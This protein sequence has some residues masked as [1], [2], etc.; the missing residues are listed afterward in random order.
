MNSICEC[1]VEENEKKSKKY[2]WEWNKQ[3]KWK[4]T[5]ILTTNYDH[6]KYNVVDIDENEATQIHIIRLKSDGKYERQ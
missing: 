4:T 1:N 5:M 6:N 2:R 3:T